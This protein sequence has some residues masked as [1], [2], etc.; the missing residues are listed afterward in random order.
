MPDAAFTHCAA[1][2]MFSHRFVRDAFIAGT[3]VTIAAGLAGYFVVLRNQ[4]FVTDV[5]SHIAF[6]GALAAYAFA[7]D[8]LFGL[9]ATT[10]A[11]AL[12]GAALGERAGGQDVI[13][14][15][16]FA[17]VLGLGVL[18]LSVYASGHG[19]T[20]GSAGI[21]VLFGSI[22]SLDRAHLLVALGTGTAVVLVLAAI[23]R[24]LLFSSLDPDVAATRGIPVRAL[25]LAFVVLVAV[26][27]AE[28]VQIVG[29]LLIIGLMVTPAAAAVRLT[30]RPYA[31]LALSP[32]IAVASLWLGLTANY[33]APDV[34]VSFAVVGIAF[35]VYVAALIA[36][37]VGPRL[38][39]AADR[40]Q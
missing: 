27:V 38:K 3:P 39:A 17:W 22:Y 13:T 19:S 5:L 30:S 9:F 25:G 4:V 37:A 12:G 16:V 7:I 33:A 1:G 2:F 10:I 40:G 26:T 14:G 32:L 24:P 28:A 31:A 11:F 36:G 29:A 15:S 23:A 20:S 35:A 18:F 8:P 21:S 34:P 6:T